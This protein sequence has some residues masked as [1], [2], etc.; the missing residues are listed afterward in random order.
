MDCIAPRGSPEPIIWWEKN[1]S[2]LQLNTQ[3]YRAFDNGTFLIPNATLVDN[4]EYRCVA[5]N[6]AG[7]RRSAPAFLNVFEKPSFLIKPQTKKY[8]T[9][10]TVRLECQAKGFPQPL[11]E[12][13]KDNSLDNMPSKAQISDN[14]LILPSVSVNDEG[15]YTQIVDDRVQ[16]AWQ[17]AASNLLGKVRSA[18]RRAGAHGRTGGL[19][20][21]GERQS[22]H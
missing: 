15:E 20:H 2:P 4:G 12:W 18:E 17:A 10:A 3:Q 13:K 5:Q 22:V 9:G 19:H 14:T 6:D 7:L 21:P 16:C 8:Q 11:I 1:G